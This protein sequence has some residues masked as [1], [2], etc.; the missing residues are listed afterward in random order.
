MVERVET[1]YVTS[2]GLCG[3]NW[4]SVLPPMEPVLSKSVHF[5]FG[6]ISDLRIVLTCALNILTCIFKVYLSRIQGYDS[7]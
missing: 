1:G 4:C 3:V 2:R 7:L 6:T 5:R